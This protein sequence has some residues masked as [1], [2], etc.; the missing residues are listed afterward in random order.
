MSAA[1]EG[2]WRIGVDIGGTF[3]DFVLVDAADGQVTLHK[4]LTTPHDPAEAA[5][6]HA[7]APGRSVLVL[8]F[9]SAYHPVDD[10]M[11]VALAAAGDHGGDH[12]EVRGGRSAEAPK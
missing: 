8:G 2:R 6:T 4:R 7:G 3:T 9:E 5:L 1:G 10:S 11:E 12:G